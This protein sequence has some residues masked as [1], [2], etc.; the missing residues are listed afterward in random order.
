[1]K[2]DITPSLLIM[3]IG[4]IQYKDYLL[5]N[6]R[7]IYVHSIITNS[8]GT[9]LKAIDNGIDVLIKIGEKDEINLVD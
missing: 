9:S 1:M 2:I 3:S 8:N 5:L 7:K 4:H 6:G